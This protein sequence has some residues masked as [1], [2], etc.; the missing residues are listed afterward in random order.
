MNLKKLLGTTL[1]MAAA[2]AGLVGCG[3]KTVKYQQGIGSVISLAETN[4][5]LTQIN[6]T[7]VSA[8]FD[9]SGKVVSAYIDEVQIPVK[10][11]DGKVAYNPTSKQVKDAGA[12]NVE[13][14]KELKERYGME[15]IGGACTEDP[16]AVAKGC[17]G[18]WFEQALLI[19]DF[20][21]GK[22]VADAV[23][24]PTFERDASH[25]NVPADGHELFGKVTMT[26]Q[27]YNAAFVEAVSH[28][29]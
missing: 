9:E 17:A 25:T 20:F 6:V 4:G 14:K 11:V 7:A 10:V 8:V 16:K 5:A 1:V 2:V 18:E 27:D 21:V 23:A 13:S 15:N 12:K 3:P 29:K 24:Q 19:E 26:I 28:S 22:K